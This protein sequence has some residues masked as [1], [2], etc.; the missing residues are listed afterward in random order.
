MRRR[1]IDLQKLVLVGILAFIAVVFTLLNPRFLSGFTPAGRWLSAV[2]GLTLALAAFFSAAHPLTLDDLQRLAPEATQEEL[3]F[4]LS[5]RVDKVLV[6]K[7]TGWM[8]SLY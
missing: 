2:F 1:S 6:D 7:N 8:R 4:L 3:G 5:G